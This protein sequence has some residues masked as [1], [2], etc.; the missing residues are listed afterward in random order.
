NERRRWL[1]KQALLRRYRA[2]IEETVAPRLEDLSGRMA[3]DASKALRHCVSQLQDHAR[4]VV[5]AFYFD[6]LSSG[7]IA[8]RFRR[9]ASWVFVVLHRARVAIG[10]CLKSKGV[11]PDE[12]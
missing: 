7:K 5:E 4:G 6:D 2:R 8:E 9:P 11:L 3:D 10:E 1:R 12:A